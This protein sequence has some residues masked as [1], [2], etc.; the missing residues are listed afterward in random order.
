MKNSLFKRAVAA[1]ATVPLALTQCLTCTSFAASTDAVKVTGDAIKAEAS[2]DTSVTLDNMLY[3][4]PDDADQ[5]SDWN[6]TLSSALDKIVSNGNTTGTLDIT[7]F[8]NALASRAGQYSDLAKAMLAQVEGVA[9]RVTDDGDILIAAK[10]NNLAAALQSDVNKALGKKVKELADK[11]NAPELA[12]I[13]FAK[14]DISGTV[15]VT[16]KTSE[17]AGGTKFTVD[18]AFAAEDGKT[19]TVYDAINTYAAGKLA[20]LKNTAYTTIDSIDG[21][22]KDAVKADVDAAMAEY[23]NMFNTATKNL[24]KVFTA[25]RSKTDTNVAGLIS[26]AKN[27]LKKNY[28]KTF[29]GST[30]SEVLATNTVGGLYNNA[31]AQINAAA[32]PYTVDVDAATLGAFLDSLTNVDYSIAGGVGSLS[33]RFEDAEKEA[34]KAYVEAQGNVFVDSY[35]EITGVVDFGGIKA[36]DASS[37]SVEVKRILVTETTTTT[38]T[39]DTTTTTSTTTTSSDTTT[40]S[41]TTTSSSNTT[42]TSATTTSSDT[43]TTSATTTSSDTTTTTT[44]ATT[45]SSDTTTTSATTTSSS[46]TTTT[47]TTT[48]SSSDTTTTSTTTTSSNT[49]TTTTTTTT[50]VVTSVSTYYVTADTDYA[51]YLNTEETFSEEQVKNA[52]VHVSYVDVTTDEEGNV[53]S[54]GDPVE[55]DI[56]IANI[57]FG[58]A[59]PENT[60]VADRTDGFDYDVTL[61]Y[62]GEDITA[63]DGTVL[64]ANGAVLANEAGEKITVKA[65][66]GVKG[67]ANLDNKVDATDASAVLTYYANLLTGKSADEV[68]LST[69]QLAKNDA[70]YEQFA[71]FLVDVNA[72]L[73]D[74]ALTKADRDK[75]INAID[76]SYILTFF[77]DRAAT[78]NEKYNTLTDKELWDLV[79]GNK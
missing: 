49:T 48:T 59:T 61:T 26:A 51:F 4:A 3:I 28:N 45:T 58:D 66:I 11:Y 27:Y 20:E 63:P 68:V 73:S 77:A 42:T 7:G 41:A 47:S 50:N 57:G 72:S 38:T 16:I 8:A 37:V 64:L 74:R 79:L 2:A 32:S 30:A 78:E 56:D 17:L 33:G 43:T 35:K 52:K 24:G 53:V 22:D 23:V 44:S 29:T 55:E 46:D 70:V 1:V 40:T 71:A 13:D 31:L 65:Y 25:N 39:G 69:S 21:I 67:D 76:A 12:N 62:E 19:Y 14:V 5:K 9:Y 75:D 34:V 54:V 6:L 18:V 36:A 60:Y 10:V 15:E